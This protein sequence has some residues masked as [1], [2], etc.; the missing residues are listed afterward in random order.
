M[1]KKNLLF[2]DLLLSPYTFAATA[3][4]SSAQIIGQRKNNSKYMYRD[5]ICG[6]N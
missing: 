1:S 5:K 2:N 6:Q 3:W 4:H